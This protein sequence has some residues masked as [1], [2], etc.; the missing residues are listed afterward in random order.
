MLSLYPIL[1]RWL[2]A[3]DPEPVAHLH[4][5]R[6]DLPNEIWAQIFQEPSLHRRDLLAVFTSCQHF[7]D[8][9][10]PIILFKS[11]T[12]PSAL[13]VGNVDIASDVVPVLNLAS[14]LPPITRMQCTFDIRGD[15]RA[16]RELRA[17]KELVAR[18]PSRVD[19]RLN[20]LGDLLSAYKSDLVP[21]TPQRTIT[22][23]FCDFLCSL[24]QAPDHPVVFVNTEIFTC[25]AADIS[26]WQLDKYMFTNTAAAGGG[27]LGLLT[28]I[29][30]L[31][32]TPARHL[33]R[34]KTSI[35]QHNG[36]H[37]AVFPFI[38]ISS[39]DIQHLHG[40][41]SSEFSSWTLVTLNAGSPHWPNVLNLSAPLAGG[42]WAAIL[43][44][45]NFP[46]L[47][48]IR[49]DPP[50]ENASDFPNIPAEV[51]DAF[52]SR[53]P[54]ITRMYYYPDPL[55]IP[56]VT[57]PHDSLNLPRMRNITTTAR[58]ALHLFR[59][60]EGAFPNLLA[61]RI[62][63]VDEPH[64]IASALRL[65]SRHAGSNKL[66]LEVSTGSW[67]AI[68]PDAAVVCALHRVD[69]VILCGYTDFVDS[70]AILRWVDL[71]PALRRVVLQ[72]CLHHDVGQQARTDFPRRAREALPDPIE[73][74]S[75]QEHQGRGLGSSGLL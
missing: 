50:Q 35:K 24:P 2:W 47:P 54:N 19:L 3:A 7:N 23:P 28:A 12:A 60:P 44:L 68:E 21:L 39:L 52:L 71:F 5:E 36:L 61:L 6:F 25:R 16:P 22:E 27:L 73:L 40:P 62:T 32:G 15:S 74:I 14:R 33:P 48:L 53:H 51:L 59:H 4:P 45:L 11:G 70:T 9:V 66:I 34:T 38:S 1:N 17:L 63:G 37:A 57:F 55:T 31:A 20:F 72:G 43:P 18:M 49:M 30:T 65:L 13:A 10:L 75:T 58:C 8:L 69:T 26:T 41:F 42:E 64:V 46:N 56:D 29:S 67:M